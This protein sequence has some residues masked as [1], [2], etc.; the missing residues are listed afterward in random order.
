MKQQSALGPMPGPKA[1]A[2][3]RK[4]KGPGRTV[5]SATGPMPKRGPGAAA[6]LNPPPARHPH[7]HG[8]ARQS[9]FGPPVP[10]RAPKPKRPKRKKPVRKLAG[11][12]LV[13]CCAAEAVAM[14]LRLA[15]GRV[16]DED[17]L[18]LYFATAGVPDDGASIGDTLDA[19]AGVGLAGI[20][21]VFYEPLI[22]T[23]AAGVAASPLAA[24]GSGL[25]WHHQI[26]IAAQSADEHVGHDLILGADAWPASG[27]LDS[28]TCGNVTININSRRSGDWPASALIGANL[29]LSGPKPVTAPCGSKFACI[30]GLDLPEGPHAVCATEDGWWSWGRLYPASAFSQAIIGEAWAVTWP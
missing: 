17:M 28:L 4:K 22:V 6:G 13:A 19:V 7:H 18:A 21:Q 16:T 2:A 29:Q 23:G 10:A 26:A 15:G 24:C 8:A 9:G 25:E 20:R 3:G 30:L 27:L 1:K 5:Q 14:S 11:S 12:S